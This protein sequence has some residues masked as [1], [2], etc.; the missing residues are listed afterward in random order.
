[1]KKTWFRSRLSDSPTW[2]P[3]K[4]IEELCMVISLI[5]HISKE[6]TNFQMDRPRV[7]QHAGPAWAIRG[8]SPLYKFDAAEGIMPEMT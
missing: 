3:S 4:G 2:S 7:V 8:H 1:V 5:G 6:Y